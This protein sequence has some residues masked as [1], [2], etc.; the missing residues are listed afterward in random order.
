MT[1]DQSQDDQVTTALRG[2]PAGEPDRLRAAHTRDRCLAALARRQQ[3][4]QR[5]TRVLGP[6]HRRVLEPA[7]IAGACLA[8]LAEVVIRALRQYRF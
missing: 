1:T 4:A 8:F 5:G 6:S 2:L 3:E 7:L